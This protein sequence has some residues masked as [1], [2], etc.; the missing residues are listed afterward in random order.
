MEEIIAI[1]KK[2]KALGRQMWLEEMV[3]KAELKEREAL[4][5]H[6]DAAIEHYNAFMKKYD[7]E[8]LMIK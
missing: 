2:L 7:L 1:E 8:Y 4:G 5:L 3:Y 6:G